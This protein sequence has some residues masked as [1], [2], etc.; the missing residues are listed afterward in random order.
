M[1]MEW[2]ARQVEPGEA[3][4]SALKELK[5]QGYNVLVDMTA[6][7]WSALGRGP[8]ADASDPMKRA[9]PAERATLVHPIASAQG[10]EYGAPKMPPE[11]SPRREAFFAP[12]PA[13]FELVY[14]LARIDPACGDDKG[15][16]EVRT[17]VSGAQPELRSAAGLWPV[18][19]WLEREVYD[20]FG[21]RFVDRPDIKRLLLY[22]EFVGHPLRKDYPITGR[23]PLIGP[24]DGQ[25]PESPTFNVI[26]PTIKYD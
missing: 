12:R 26:R 20:M 19:D 8:K 10:E 23:Q 5:E 24:A 7:D 11:S 21:L 18:A 14:R 6:I 22:E 2:T 25:R 9:A 3:C 13:R 17:F 1:S 4:F 15:R 16:A